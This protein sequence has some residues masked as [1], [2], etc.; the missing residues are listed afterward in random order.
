[1]CGFGVVWRYREIVIPFVR[2]K[3]VQ[4]NDGGKMPQN[5]IESKG[6]T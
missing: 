6:R 1:M 4:T 2:E 5:V 3:Q